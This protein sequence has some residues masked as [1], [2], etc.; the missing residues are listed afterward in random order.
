[1]EPLPNLLIMFPYSLWRLLVFRLFFPNSSKV[2]KLSICADVL[3]SL[4][5]VLWCS[6]QTAMIHADVVDPFSVFP[7]RLIFP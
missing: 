5:G 2:P 6:N 3:M 7:C 1:M 4:S